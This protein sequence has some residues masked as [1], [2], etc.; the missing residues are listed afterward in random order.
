MRIS[1]GWEELGYCERTNCMEFDGELWEWMCMPVL[2]GRL[3]LQIFK[4]YIIVDLQQ[5]VQLLK[6]N[7]AHSDLH[8][9]RISLGETIATKAD[10]N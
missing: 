5:G 1:N 3:R 9:L 8:E 2:L 10:Q 7:N 4:V 6:A